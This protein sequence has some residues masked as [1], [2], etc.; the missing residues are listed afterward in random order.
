MPPDA[1]SLRTR[2]E[3]R[4]TE[5]AEQLARRLAQ[6]DGEIAAARD[7]GCYPH[8]VVNDVLES[9]IEEVKT[10]VAKEKARR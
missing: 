7:S 6:A 10:I 3:G 4:R 1:Q 8:F 2:L 5:A 9:T